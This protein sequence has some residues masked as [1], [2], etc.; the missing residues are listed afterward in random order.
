MYQIAYSS[1][2]N[3]MKDIIKA[4]N[5]IILNKA[6]INSFFSK[7]KSLFINQGRILN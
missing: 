4:V 7:K 3:D 2:I 6:K 1:N 5:K